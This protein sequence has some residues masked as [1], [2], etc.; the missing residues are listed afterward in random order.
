MLK[1]HC[2][3]INTVVSMHNNALHNPTQHNNLG[4]SEELTVKEMLSAKACQVRQLANEKT[5][6]SKTSSVTFAVNLPKLRARY[7]IIHCT[8]RPLLSAVLGRTKFCSQKPRI[9]EVRG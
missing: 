3:H 9:N 6:T 2:W 8:V 4:N 7:N 5:V 1:C